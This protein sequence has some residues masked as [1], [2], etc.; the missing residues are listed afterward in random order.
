MTI[1]PV[2]NPRFAPSIEIVRRRLLPKPGE[3]VVRL[4]DRVNGNDTVARTS[5][6]GHLRVID[7]AKELR[8]DTGSVERHLL[9][10]EGQ[11][12]AAGEE[13]ARVQ[14]GRV[15]LRRLRSPY[16]GTVAG[17]H[18]GRVFLRQE[19]RPLELRAYVP[20]EVI[21]VFPHRGVSIRAVG[22]LIAG[23]WASG[24]DQQGFLL[25]PVAHHDAPLT[26][27][28]VGIRYRG[29]ILV[30]GTLQ[31]PRVLYRARQFRVHGLLVGSMHPALRPICER[32]GLT[33]V[34]IEGM[35]QIPMAEPVFRLLQSFHGHPAIL[36]GAP[37][38]GGSGPEAFIPDGDTNPTMMR[39]YHTIEADMLVRLTRPPF[40]GL[41]ARVESI[42]PSPQ[43]TA[44]GIHAEGAVVRLPDGQRLFVPL[45]NLEPLA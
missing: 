41:V 21:E 28:Q 7:V 36:G 30:G 13:L 25:V 35:G 39:S 17:I 29:T 34:I 2:Q 33:V 24:S 12:I 31:D 23:I 11:A 43:P 8:V 6:E 18:E 4:G 3:V 15:S 19:P 37:E 44:V 26:W 10:R 1:V 22:A 9:V 32:L 27:Q 20:G 38:Q 42:P 45:A 5:L 16:A 14:R 40:V